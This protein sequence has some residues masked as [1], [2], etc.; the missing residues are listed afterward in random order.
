MDSP[1]G[2]LATE[3]KANVS[4]E[5]VIVETEITSGTGGATLVTEIGHTK[6]VSA[7]LT[8]EWTSETN[9]GEKTAAGPNKRIE[10]SFLLS[11]VGDDG[12][13]PKADEKVVE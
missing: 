11:I 1:D 9:L 5:E 13:T 2:S 8:L 12:G 10:G 7:C 4:T 3:L 6:I